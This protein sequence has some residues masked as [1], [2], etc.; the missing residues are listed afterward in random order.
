MSTYDKYVAG[1]VDIMGVY[2]QSGGDAKPVGGGQ[3]RTS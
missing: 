2:I 1:K 3:D